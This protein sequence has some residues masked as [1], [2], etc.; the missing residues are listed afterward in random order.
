M[1]RLMF[2]RPRRIEWE[3]LTPTFGRMTAEPFEKGYALTV[4]GSLRRVLVIASY[5][6]GRNKTRVD[7]LATNMSCA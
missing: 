5:P 2:Q 6:L 4:G 7:T 1:P 3:N